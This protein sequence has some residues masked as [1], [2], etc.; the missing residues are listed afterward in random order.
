MEWHEWLSDSNEQEGARRASVVEEIEI[1]RYRANYP[2]LT[3]DESFEGEGNLFTG[4]HLHGE[5]KDAS[6]E[7]FKTHSLGY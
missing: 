2:P 7:Y 1:K 4:Y 5:P 6:A 3:S